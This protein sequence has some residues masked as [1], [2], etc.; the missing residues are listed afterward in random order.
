MDK[1]VERGD[2]ALDGSKNALN[3]YTP[4]MFDFND[5][6]NGFEKGSGSK[7]LVSQDS[8]DSQIPSFSRVSRSDCTGLVTKTAHNERVAP[9]G[10]RPPE[11]RGSPLSKV[12]SHFKILQYPYV[13]FPFRYCIFYQ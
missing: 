13:A 7:V 6:F 5:L 11:P 4:R 9:W 3:I 2:R 10:E 8:S 12:S 1:S